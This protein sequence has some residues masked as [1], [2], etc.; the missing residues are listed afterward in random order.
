MC[1]TFENCKAQQNLENF[2]STKV[3]LQVNSNKQN[4]INNAE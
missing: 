1:E 3:N 2:H 4:K